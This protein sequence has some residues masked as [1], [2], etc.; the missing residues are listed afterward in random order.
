MCSARKKD[1]NK[2]AEKFFEDISVGDKIKTATRKITRD[3]IIA[4]AKE[5][6]PQPMHLTDEGGQNSLFGELVASG[7]HTF[8]LTM[9]LV[10]DAKPLGDTPLIGMKVEDVRLTKPLKPNDEIYA[11][12]EITRKKESTS[13]KHIGYVTVKTETFTIDQTRIASQ[14][15]VIVVPKRRT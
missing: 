2:M 11:T 7:W 12:S 6:D 9:R 10:V 1:N 13:K 5:Y 4:F 8:T 3:E 15:W 14:S